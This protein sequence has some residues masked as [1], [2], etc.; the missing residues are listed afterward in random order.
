MPAVY[1]NTFELIYL[2]FLRIGIP[3]RFTARQACADIFFIEQRHVCF[4]HMSV[5]DEH[6][7]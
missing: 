7:P 2:G 4:A 3:L 5:F 6:A 1:A